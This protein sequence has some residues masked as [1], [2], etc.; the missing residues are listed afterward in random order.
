M[1]VTG[2]YGGGSLGVKAVSVTG[3]TDGPNS[4]PIRAQLDPKIQPTSTRNLQTLT[5][6]TLQTPVTLEKLTLQTL[7]T[8]TLQTLTLQTLRTLTRNP[9]KP[10]EKPRNIDEFRILGAPLGRT[11]GR[12]GGL[13]GLLGAV[14]GR[15]GTVLGRLGALLGRLGALWGRLGSLLGLC[16]AVAWHS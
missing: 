2:A 1:S 16:W 5:L 8:L 14:W 12:L 7:H 13:L 3:P 15:L 6:Q 11:L 9:K 4:T 10:R